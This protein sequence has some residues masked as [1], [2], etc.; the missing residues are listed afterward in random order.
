MSRSSPFTA[1]RI[2]VRFLALS[3]GE[4]QWGG[5]ILTEIGLAEGATM[6]SRFGAASSA[7]LKVLKALESLLRRVSLLRDAVYFRLS[8]FGP[9][10]N[11]RPPV[12]TDQWIGRLTLPLLV[13]VRIAG[14]SSGRTVDVSFMVAL[15]QR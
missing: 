12:W 15:R 1:S 6:K 4:A 9:L 13:S 14:K 10:E 8:Y 7:L 2:A 5:L 3:E 11:G